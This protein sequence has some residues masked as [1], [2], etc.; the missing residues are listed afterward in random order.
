MMKAVSGLKVF[1]AGGEASQEKS[2]KADLILGACHG[3][4]GSA[5]LRRKGKVTSPMEC[6]NEAAVDSWMG[7]C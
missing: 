3:E 6:G 5:C 2:E 7:F 1:P 4:A